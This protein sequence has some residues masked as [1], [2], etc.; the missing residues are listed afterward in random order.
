MKNADLR[1][2]ALLCELIDTQS[3]SDAAA[4]L[5]MSPSAASQALG[6]LRHAL[7]DE[8]CVRHQQRYQLTPQG[9]AVLAPL[10]RIVE[11]WREAS[12]GS[13][14]F[15]P[16]RCDARL[17]LACH[18]GFGPA[19]LAALA[20]D[21]HR[22]APRVTWTIG[23]PDNG[24]RDIEA[25]RAGEV[26]VVCAPVASP[27][28]ARDLHAETL[29]RWTVDTC[30][31][32]ADHPRIGGAITGPQYLAESHLDLGLTGG[33]AHAIDQALQ[34][35]G[36]PPRNAD[37]VASLAVCAA[38]LARTDRLAST[39][40]AQ[41]EALCRA[42]AGLRCLPLPAGP[43]WPVVAVQM[44]WHQRTHQSR[45]HRWLRQRLRE[46]LATAAGA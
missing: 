11:L 4:R 41:A 10:R 12:G 27:E 14:L 22:A 39:S 6:R 43:A 28:D 8:L 3:L 15:D 46:H 7:G 2:L 26:D 29:A 37:A 1:Q 35:A 5:H 44:L 25:L 18:D 38:L 13:V 32:R 40:A 23:M 24:P 36:W 42:A 31:L 45:P 21:I 9:E 20:D 33:R 19:R 17:R 34:A 16:A 30:C